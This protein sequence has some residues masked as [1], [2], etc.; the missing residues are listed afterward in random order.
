MEGGATVS[1]PEDLR[2]QFITVWNYLLKELTVAIEPIAFALQ[3]APEDT[4]RF[5]A[6]CPANASLHIE[7]TPNRVTVSENGSTV[8]FQDSAGNVFQAGGDL[9]IDESMVPPFPD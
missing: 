6:F 8:W 7:I 4:L 9:E 5:G 1:K 2:A 3:I